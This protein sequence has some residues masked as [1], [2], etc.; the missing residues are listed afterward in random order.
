MSNIFQTFFLS[1]VS[2]KRSPLALVNGDRWRTIAKTFS[3]VKTNFFIM[4]TYRITPQP[5]NHRFQIELTITPADSH[6]TLSMANWTSGSYLIRDY[7][8]RIRSPQASAGLLFQRDKSHW[9][10]TALTPNHPLTIRWEVFAY[11]Q[12]IHDAWLDADRGFFNPAAL[13]LIPSQYS[14]EPVRL[15]FADTTFTP[16][17]SLSQTDTFQ[18][19][20][21]DLHTMLDAPVT[22]LRSGAPHT[23]IQVKSHGIPHRLLITGRNATRLNTDKLR[24]DLSAI[25][26]TT[27]SFWGR[28]PFSDY[29]FHLHL[30]TELYGGLEHDASCVLQMDPSSLPGQH[31]SVPPKNYADFLTLV[32]HEYFHAWL[33]KFLRPAH[34]LPYD[35]S[36]ECHSHDLWVFEGITSY[37]ESLLPLRAGVISQ[38]EFFSQI[39]QRFNRV[40]RREGFTRQSLEDASFNAWTHLYKQTADSPYCQTSYYGKGAILAFMLD[41]A[42][43]HQ[44][45]DASLDILLKQWFD[46]AL[47]DPTKRGLPDRHFFNRLPS[48][49]MAAHFE[50]LARST[51]MEQWQNTWDQTLL[52]LGLDETPVCDVDVSETLLGLVLSNKDG[53]ILV[54]HTA[55]N[56]SAFDSGLFAEDE[57]VALDHYRVTQHSFNRQIEQSQGQTLSLHFFRQGRLFETTLHIPSERTSVHKKLEPGNLTPTG[58]AWLGMVV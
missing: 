37:Y 22:L 48:H 14:R 4:L 31:E 33:V 17:T 45:P 56:G 12:G 21:P 29:L 34:F 54:R 43:R 35:L 46:E 53:R 42:L 39:N 1:F 20:A 26:D 10:L 18:Y 51:D 23:L 49:A 2:L 36:S 19:D 57:I 30:G 11:S 8:G 40:R 7:A 24:R 5:Q 25:L 38:T 13:F 32:A 16:Y 55:A 52:I 44:A 6:L 3:V 27:L 9:E 58:R 50:H 15:I 28:A 41:A 47:S